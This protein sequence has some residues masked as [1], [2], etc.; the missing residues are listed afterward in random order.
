[1]FAMMMNPLSIDARNFICAEEEEEGLMIG[2][3]QVKAIAGSNFELSSIYVSET[4]RRRGIG[5][6]LVLYLV[7]NFVVTHGPSQLDCLYLLTLGDRVG[8]YKK[9]GFE[10]IAFKDTP[11]A[12]NAE[13]VVGSFLQ[14]F[15]GNSCV[16][17][18]ANRALAS[19]KCGFE[20]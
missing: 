11:A 2:F 5:S 1:M 20:A 12:I 13:L 16:C 15:S 6:N 19:S 10:V 14:F 9:L 7:K 8:F 4:H 17:M 3:G 18:R